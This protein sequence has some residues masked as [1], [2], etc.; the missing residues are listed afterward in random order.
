MKNLKKDLQAVNREIKALS[1]K[2]DR[3]LVAAGK[4]EKP[5]LSKQNQ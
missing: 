1:K 5:K 4:L 3:M 2:V